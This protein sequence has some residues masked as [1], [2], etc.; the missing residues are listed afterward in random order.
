MATAP[1]IYR[2]G[3]NLYKTVEGGSDVQLSGD[4]LTSALA[5][6][7]N[8]LNRIQAKENVTRSPQ[9]RVSRIKA[10][11]ASSGEVTPAVPGLETTE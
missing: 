8:D 5:S 2:E 3:Q 4:E 10:R 9:E 11:N 1:Q 6:A 7:G